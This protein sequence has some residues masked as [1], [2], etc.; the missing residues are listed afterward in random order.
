[1]Y[2]IAVNA[3]KMISSRLN[4][5]FPDEMRTARSLRSRKSITGDLKQGARVRRST[6]GSPYTRY[7]IARIIYLVTLNT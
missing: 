5:T 6:I 7:I 2:L 1:M 4:D 3:I